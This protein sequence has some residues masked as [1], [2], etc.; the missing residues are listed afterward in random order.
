MV[1]VKRMT[2]V[3]TDLGKMAKHNKKAVKVKRIVLDSI[4]DKLIPHIAEKSTRDMYDALITLYR[5]EYFLKNDPEE[6]A[7]YHTHE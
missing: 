6:Q 3:P 2:T 1:F 7:H 4:K 5:S